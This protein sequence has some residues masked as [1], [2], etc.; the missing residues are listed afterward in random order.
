MNTPVAGINLLDYANDADGDT[1]YVLVNG[2]MVALD[3]FISGNNIDASQ[4]VYDGTD[5]TFTPAD[6]YVG[7]ESFTVV[8]WDGQYDYVDG[9]KGDK[10]T[11]SGQ[12]TV[13]TTN[14]KPTAEGDLGSF[15][16]D[17]GPIIVIQDGV[18][19][20]VA[21]NDEF[22]PQQT[23]PDDLSI[24]PGVYTG[25]N[26]G[27][28]EF[29]GTNWIYNP[30]QG[31]SGTETFDGINVWDG[32][33]IY[34]NGELIGPEYGQG[35][36]SVTVTAPEVIPAAPLPLLE[37]PKLV[38]CP[39]LLEAAANELAVNSDELQLLIANAMATNPNLQPCDAC[40]NL[41][42]AASAL[43][44]INPEIIAAMNL[45]FNNLAPLDTPFTPEAS[46]SVRTAFANF[47]DMEP[48]L[49]IMSAEQYEQYQQYMLA[50]EVIEAFVSYV[51]VLDN[52]L[53]LPV[54]DAM[55]LVI[56][57][58]FEPIEAS[59]NPNIGAYIIEQIIA[60]QSTGEPIVASAD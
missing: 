33:N 18:V 42:E 50:D 47:R 29:D 60:S 14:I 3:D 5:W 26:G 41:L 32:Q 48:Q 28:L 46:A 43:K 38:G 10:V 7:P 6:G 24:I 56:D 58:Y 22:D 12:L 35:T 37:I 31:F 54:G 11:V 25:S 44:G 2:E 30:A 9:V 52:D 19:S 8:V 21:V 34:E 27:T 13:T 53:K 51:A 15:D 36:V 16:L 23:A 1:L 40:E 17:D 20:P 59:G 55:A 45:I 39:V 57:K 4:I 49:A